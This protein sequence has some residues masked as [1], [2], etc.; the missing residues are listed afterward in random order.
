LNYTLTSNAAK[1]LRKSGVNIRRTREL[2]R[3]QG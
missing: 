2:K 1:S 3:A